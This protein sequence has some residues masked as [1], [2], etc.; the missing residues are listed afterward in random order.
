MHKQI[1]PDWAQRLCFTL[2]ATGSPRNASPNRLPRAG[3]WLAG[4]RARLR[5]GGGAKKPRGV[6]RSQAGRVLPARASGL[7]AGWTRAADGQGGGELNGRGA[8][9]P[10][11]TGQWQ[12]GAGKS[13]A[14]TNGPDNFGLRPTCATCSHSTKPAATIT[15]TNSGNP[16]YAQR[17]TDAPKLMCVAKTPEKL[18][19]PFRRFSILSVRSFG[20]ETIKKSLQ[21]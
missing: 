19:T 6:P 1:T 18:L 21:P 4:V 8:V 14:A 13:S 12:A 2:R 15:G 7:H 5:L 10:S 3:R 9:G 20:R 17:G 16:P 11:G